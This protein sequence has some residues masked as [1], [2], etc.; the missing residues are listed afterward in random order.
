MR[1][2]AV[3][4]LAVGLPLLSVATAHA[5]TTTVTISGVAWKDLNGD[6]I[7]Q[8][9][10]PLLPGI[11]IEN[12][13][14]DATGHYTITGV[15]PD[16]PSL[17]APARGIE[18]GKYVLTRPNQGDPATDS[19][20]DW[21]DGWL[22]L[23]QKPVDGAIANVDVGF[24]PAKSDATVN[25]VAKQDNPVHVG[26]DVTYEIDIEN[27]EFPS[28]VGVRV[29][30][31]EGVVLDP[32]E[33]PSSWADP[34]GTTGL[35]IRFLRAAEPNMPRIR[36]VSGKVTKPIDGQVTA[37]LIDT[38]SD[39]NPLNDERSALLKAI[40]AG[41]ATPTTT[42]K[43]PTTTKPAP[44]TSPKAQPVVKP[45]ELANTGAD[46]VWPLVAGLTL[47]AGGVGTVL[48]ARRRRA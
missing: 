46:P 12:T 11:K 1:R 4:A 8:P 21:N 39:V 45:A 34:V 6:G 13:V 47:L 23:H 33:G 35:D 27:N 26:D 40:D 48:F 42:T 5:D 9:T 22:T 7:R 44:T 20:F 16:N 25:I 29:V 19:D 24:M 37:K 31:P 2:F 36:E 28:Y 15:S 3:A 10:E 32:Y 43:A 18:G 38:N 17:Q 14:T 41:G 30:F